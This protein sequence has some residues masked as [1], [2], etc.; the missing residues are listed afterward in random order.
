MHARRLQVRTISAGK[1]GRHGEAVAQQ[2]N[3]VVQLLD[4]SQTWCRTAASGLS[5]QFFDSFSPVQHFNCASGGA[6]ANTSYILVAYFL[7]L[8]V[9]WLLVDL[10]ISYLRTFEEHRPEALMKRERPNVAQPHSTQVNAHRGVFNKRRAPAQSESLPSNIRI[11]WSGSGQRDTRKR[12]AEPAHIRAAIGDG[13]SLEAPVRSDVGEAESGVQRKEPT[14]GSARRESCEQGNRDA[15]EEGAF[16]TGGGEGGRGKGP[17]EQVEIDPGGIT[18]GRR[19]DNRWFSRRGDA[20]MRARKMVLEMN[21]GNIVSKF[22]PGDRTR[23]SV[24]AICE[25]HLL[26]T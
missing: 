15:R 24:R 18:V 16:N 5:D 19:D 4:V 11:K 1:A 17:A 10:C 2:L 25:G 22:G 3:Y 20:G 9:A 7:A 8:R 26:S 23:T 12:L 14:V 13:G 6:L 21:V